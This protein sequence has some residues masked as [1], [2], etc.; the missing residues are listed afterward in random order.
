M[1]PASDVDL[2][3]EYVTDTERPELFDQNYFTTMDVSTQNHVY[4]DIY[5]FI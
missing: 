1:T 5:L 4:F 2:N 3:T